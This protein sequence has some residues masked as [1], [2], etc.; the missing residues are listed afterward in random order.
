MGTNIEQKSKILAKNTLLL[1]FRLLFSMVISLYTSRA[2]LKYL[3]AEDYGIY[4]VVGGVVTMFSLVSGT[5]SSS[6]SRNL[7]FELGQGN[8]EKLRKTFSMS[9]NVQ[10]CLI[11][12]ILV[13]T[14]TIGVWFL[15][16]K[17]N[18][19]NER[20]F[21][22]N[23]VLQFSILT[24][25]LN[26]FSVPYNASIISHEK[27]KS[28][29]YIGMLEVTLKL[30]AVFL[31][32]FNPFDKLVYYATLLFLVSVIIQ[33]IYFVYCKKN[34]R[35]CTY[36]FCFDYNILKGLLGF[37]GWNFLGSAAGLLK[38]QGLNILLNLF[39]GTIVNAARAIATQVN[40]AINGF[41]S[42]FMTAL[43]PQITKAYAQKDYAY[44]VQCI[45]KG[46]K[47]SYFLLFF[48]SLPILVETEA[49]LTL[50]LVNVPDTTINFVRY[51]IICSLADTLSRT[52]I[53]ANNA[54]GNIRDYQIVIGLFNLLILPVAY[55]G[56]KL[57][58]KAESTE[59]ISCAFMLISILPRIYFVKKNIPI[60]YLGY[61][62]SVLSPIFFT[63]IVAVTL[64]VATYILVG[65]IRF[66]V[67][68]VICM[69]VFISA[70]SILFIGMS[71]TERKFIYNI[72]QKKCKR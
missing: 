30:L 41:V 14:E 24:F 36:R 63:S 66:N 20:M 33:S 17:M 19:V 23:W 52:T 44:V 68:I 35:E 45:Y 58:I 59:L 6:V 56:L 26:L 32:V 16:C 29:A 38:N 50:W 54:T 65:N 8:F 51:I 13:L 37:A 11:L 5:L 4:N 3:G 42:N 55:I 47:Y 28:F 53:H 12:I 18:I 48:L 21:A 71:T 15:N 39:F 27:M 43:V 40:S 57:G 67:F 49:I 70:M 7:T 62:K 22:A 25:A 2:I 72:I 46:S 9:V 31:L 34:F 60:S 69:C 1:Y 64:S 61:L 10:V